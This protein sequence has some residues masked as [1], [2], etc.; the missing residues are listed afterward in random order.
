MKT[1]SPEN[2]PLVLIVDDDPTIRILANQVLQLAG[3]RTKVAAGGDEAL[4]MIPSLS[5]DLILLDLSMP[6]ADGFTVCEALRRSG[7]RIPVVIMT[8]TIDDETVGKIREAGAADYI[9]KPPDWIK[10]GSRLRLVLQG[11]G[12]LQRSPTEIA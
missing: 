3:F 4:A 8:G 10:L 1:T 12:A 5:P 7:T 9:S 6:A 2:N 11:R